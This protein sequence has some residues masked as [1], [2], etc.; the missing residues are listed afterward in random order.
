MIIRLNKILLIRV[1][2]LL[3]VVWRRVVVVVWVNV[4]Q[5]PSSAPSPSP[6]V[7]LAVVVSKCGVRVNGLEEQET[8][9]IPR[10]QS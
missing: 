3:C 6:L 8:Q 9:M 1:N 2:K 4:V 10:Y 7:V 5:V